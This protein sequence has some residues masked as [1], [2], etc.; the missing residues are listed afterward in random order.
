M[1]RYVFLILGSISMCIYGLM[2]NWTVF[3]PAVQEDLQISA[4]SVANVFSVCQICFTTGGMISGFLY[5]KLNYKISMIFATVMICGGLFLTSQ[6]TSAWMIYL[7]YSMIFT[8]GAGFAYKSLLTAVLTWFDDKPGLASGILVMGAGLTA[9]VFNV[10]MS[11][12]IE[13]YGWRSAMIILSIIAIIFTMVTAIV[14]VPANSGKKSA[15][16]IPDDETQIPTSKM[17]Q[18]AKFYVYFIWSVLLLAGCTS[19][20]GNA[21]NCGKSFG[22]SATAAASLSMI[23]SLFNSSSR[24]VYGMIYDK[25]GRKFAMG[26]ATTLYAIA[27]GLLFSAFATK[28]TFLLSGCYVFIG[29]TFGAVPTL[30]STYIL[31]TFGKKYYPSNFS[32]QGLYSLFSS[33]SGTMLFSAIF[34]KTG[35]YSTSYSFLIGYAIIVV[36]LYVALNRMFE[37]TE[38]KGS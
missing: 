21:V 32:I 23:I 26:I 38:K 18:N 35:V 25:K 10:P 31:K 12:A 20:S 27:I 29:L 15:V 4:A 1:K 37:K 36:V 2:Y 11:V 34:A 5:Y 17:L 33:F 9:F 8:L 16:E 3:S 6:I 28:S 30:S 14:V 24:I 22:I 19:L 13:T 7:C